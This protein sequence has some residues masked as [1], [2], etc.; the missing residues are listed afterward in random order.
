MRKLSSKLPRSSPGGSSFEKCEG[1]RFRAKYAILRFFECRGRASG[2][3]G[4]IFSQ[5]TVPRCATRL[6]NM[7]GNGCLVR[8]LPPEP[9]GYGPPMEAAGIGS[10]ENCPASN[11][12][13]AKASLTCFMFLFKYN[14]REMFSYA[15]INQLCV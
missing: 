2:P 15:N 13:D 7:K 6:Q 12:G 1:G 14:I 4:L 5:V 11:S 10:R 3:I 9:F 8:C